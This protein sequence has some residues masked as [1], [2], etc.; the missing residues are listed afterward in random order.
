MIRRFDTK[1]II[2]VIIIILLLGSLS[3]FFI[4]KP[5]FNKY[6]GKI[7][8]EAQLEL[9]NYMINQTNNIGYTTLINENNET[10][11]LVKYTPK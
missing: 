3:Y 4:G 2:A 1:F 8:T 5:Y 11:I 7:K 6:I 9:V 10:Y